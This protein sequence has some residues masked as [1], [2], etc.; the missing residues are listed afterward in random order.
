MGEKRREFKAP[1][2]SKYISIIII[3]IITIITARSVGLRARLRMQ[4][5]CGEDVGLGTVA[6][7]VVGA[8]STFAQCAWP[9]M[10]R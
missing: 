8:V 9:H 5:R 7:V 10:H 2:G 3:T 4:E 1:A 6:F